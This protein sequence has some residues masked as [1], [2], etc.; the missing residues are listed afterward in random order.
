MRNVDKSEFGE[1]IL[2][3]QD[4][5]MNLPGYKKKSFLLYYNGGE[6]WFEHLDGIYE[7]EGLVIQ[8][9]NKDIPLFSRPS[10]TSFICFVFGETIVTDNIFLAVKKAVLESKKGFKKIA[11]C[12]LDR[13]KQKKFKKS[14]VNHGFEIGFFEGLEDAKQWLLP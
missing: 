13:K 8:K 7:N 14:F 11:F 9:L 4:N 1:M 12:G 2:T 10:S 6:I 3:Y 5:A